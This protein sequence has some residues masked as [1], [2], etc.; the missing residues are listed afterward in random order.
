MNTDSFDISAAG[1]RSEW[2]LIAVILPGWNH[3]NLLIYGYYDAVA[4]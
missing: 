4:A 1:P 3:V 2:A